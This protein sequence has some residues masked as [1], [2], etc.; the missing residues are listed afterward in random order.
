[1]LAQLAADFPDFWPEWNMP[2]WV[3][4]LLRVVG[5]LVAVLLLALLAPAAGARPALAVA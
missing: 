4:S 5:G 1:M 3:T 2:Y